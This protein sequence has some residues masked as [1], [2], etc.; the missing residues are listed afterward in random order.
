MGIDAVLALAIAALNNSAALMALFEKMKA[1]G[2][3]E[4]TT[5][6]MDFVRGQAKDA[7]D[8]LGADLAAG[9]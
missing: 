1:E 8:K 6:E 9:T 3:T 4:L 5:E 2:R 7:N